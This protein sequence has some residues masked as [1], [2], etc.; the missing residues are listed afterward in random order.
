MG[1]FHFHV[2]FRDHLLNLTSSYACL[3]LLATQIN[4]DLSME[5]WSH[6]LKIVEWNYLSIRKL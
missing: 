6:V 4:F 2:L 1:I 3:D 5:K